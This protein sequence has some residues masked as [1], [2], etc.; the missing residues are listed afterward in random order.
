VLG[1]A[2]T[3]AGCTTSAPPRVA[4]APAVRAAEPAPLPYRWTQGDAP[5]AYKD[6]VAQF[7]QL[8]MKPGQYR[9]AGA[10]PDSGETR[11]VI[12][13]MTQL[14]YVYRGD[15]LVGVTTISSGKKGRETPLG[16]WAVM[17]KKQ[18]GFSR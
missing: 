13:L 5:Q 4:A 16:F 6:A 18:K 10:I 1:G 2:L 12:D 3:L 7:G 17:L 11:V 9:W 14:F 15:K 8:A